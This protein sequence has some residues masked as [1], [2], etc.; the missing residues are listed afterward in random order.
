MDERPTEELMNTLL[1]SGSIK[2]FIEENKDSFVTETFGEYYLQVL[3][4]HHLTKSE[5]I[6]QSGIDVN[7]GYQILRDFKKKP[8]RD[9]VLCLCFG[10]KMTVLEA[11]RALRLSS[12]PIL[13]PKNRRDS[14]LLHA[15]N[16]ALTLEEC[17]TRLIREK[18]KPLIS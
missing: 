15:L 9:L 8:S 16:N 14:I 3:E 17:N 10:A 13:Y 4:K 6:R 5:A 7:Y 12:L 2:S 18:E 1:R 11:Q